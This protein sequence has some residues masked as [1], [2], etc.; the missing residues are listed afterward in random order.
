MKAVILIDLPLHY[1][2]EDIVANVSVYSRNN[3][4]EPKLFCDIPVKPLPTYRGGCQSVWNNGWNA[5]LE[6][7]EGK[8]DF[9]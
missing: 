6:K 4:V 2:Y 3:K 1:Q 5:C 9:K 7:I 8:V